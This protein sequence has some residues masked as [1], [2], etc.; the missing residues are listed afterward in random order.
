MISDLVSFSVTW[1]YLDRFLIS[2]AL[3]AYKIFSQ[4][5]QRRC[6]GDKNFMKGLASWALVF[7]HFSME[8]PS[9]CLWSS[10]DITPSAHRLVP[11]A[12]GQWMRVLVEFCVYSCLHHLTKDPLFSLPVQAINGSAI[13][14]ENRV[15]I[16]YFSCCVTHLCEVKRN[17]VTV[18]KCLF[19][20]AYL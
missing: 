4:N 20:L 16:F 2:Y 5:S 19:W 14:R 12:A 10:V 6:L 13:L 1:M 8:I 15:L 11:F 18:S 17:C 7:V 3:M 9:A